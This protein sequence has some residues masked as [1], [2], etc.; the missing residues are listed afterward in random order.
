MAWRFVNVQC[1]CAILVKIQSTLNLLHISLQ[2]GWFCIECKFVFFE[3][4][5]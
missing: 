3:L 1:T 5:A 2:A 4:T